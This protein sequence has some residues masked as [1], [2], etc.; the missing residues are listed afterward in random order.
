MLGLKKLFFIFILGSQ[1][2]LLVPTVATAGDLSEW[3][4]D[5]YFPNNFF[6]ALIEMTS[7]DKLFVVGGIP[8]PDSELRSCGLYIS[9]DFGTTW[10]S[11][12][13]TPECFSYLS[14]SSDGTRITAAQWG[15]EIFT[16]SNGGNTWVNQ[17]QAKQ[18]WG[19]TSSASGE[20]V[21]GITEKMTFWVSQD[22]GATWV[23]PFE[24]S[25]GGS[26]TK[27]AISADGQKILVG[28][29]V[30]HLYLSTDR[31]INWT[32]KGEVANWYA[33][34]MSSNGNRLF[35][36]SS[37]DG[38]GVGGIFVSE[39]DG[40]SWVKTGGDNTWWQIEA[41]ANGKHLIATPTD[42]IDNIFVSNDFGQSWQRAPGRYLTG[43][44]ALSSN[45]QYAFALLSQNL[46]Y[47]FK[48]Y[49]AEYKCG[50]G[51]VD[52]CAL[53][54]EARLK[55]AQAAAAA[56]RELEKREARQEV[57][58]RFKEGKGLTLELITKSEI[59]GITESNF[60]KFTTEILSLPEASR[61]DIN[62]IIKIAYKYEVVGKIA[63]KQ[64]EYLLP[65]TFVEI[66]LIPAT[67]KNK[68][69]LVAA[70]RKLPQESRDSYLEIKAAIQSEMMRIQ[71]RKDRLADVIA[72]NANRN[73]L[74]L[75]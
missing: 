28:D 1:F 69:A 56:K 27:S 41:T 22:F 37:N 4:L 14:A 50:I 62:Q 53:E 31:G 48:L 7:G 58:T 2:G 49:S 12:G 16:S 9:S 57:S 35:A 29:S 51:G 5:T 21:V 73:S 17:H 64:I 38:G 10:N 70:V 24:S 39:N 19:F 13:A 30:G 71:E 75:K 23:A 40:N 33:V 20:V 47:R 60:E 63:S 52:L 43:N 59:S 74:R 66:D 61:S 46:D 6:P 8:D 36:A 32:T 72:R 3:K 68:V 55:A 42:I 26:F 54:A 65:N 34:A 45:G 11:V 44:I 25:P 67:N 15:G 18:W